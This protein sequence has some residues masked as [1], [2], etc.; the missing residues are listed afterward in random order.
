MITIRELAK[1][2]GLSPT[3]VSMVLTSAPLAKNIP[4]E[5]KHRVRTAAKEFGYSPNPFARY[6]RSSRSDTVAV[7]LSD[8]TDPYC[9]EVLKGIESSLYSSSYV[10]VLL[11]IQNSRAKFKRNLQ[12]LVDRRLE[13]IIGVANS[14]LLQTALLATIEKQ[15]IPIVLIGRETEG[16]GISSVSIENDVGAHLAIKH[17]YRLGH[18]KIGFLRGP[19]DIVDSGRRWEGITQFANDA[20][21]AIDPKLVVQLQHPGTS[22]EAG[23][24][25]AGELL[26]RK[27]QFTALLAFDDLTAF[28][29]IRALTLAGRNV[30]LDCSVIGFDDVTAAAFYNPPLTTI[31]QPMETLG[32][33]AVQIFFDLADAFFTKEELTPVHHK[34]K[35][36]LVIRD[37]TSQLRP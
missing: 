16:M 19:K 4:E 6:L 12:K 1:K 10:P 18:R 27:Q 11:D 17:L 30:P 28:G 33:S 34:I 9:A 21:L 26:R 15:K 3:T 2:I 36:K 25:A 20:G 23:F 24:K 5:T 13:G 32:A 29:A 31:R 14:L 35:P 22:H 7:L 37:S 8:I